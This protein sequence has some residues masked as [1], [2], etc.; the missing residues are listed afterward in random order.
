MENVYSALSGEEIRK[1]V[2][3]EVDKYLQHDSR[4]KRSL[5]YHKIGW[6]WTLNL[7]AYGPP[8]QTVTAEGEIYAKTL[9][10][11]IDRLKHEVIDMNDL[12]KKVHAER[13]QEIAL[14]KEQLH[15]AQEY[16]NQLL[17]QATAPAPQP[18]STTQTSESED[19]AVEFTIETTQPTIEEPD[20]IREQLA[21]TED[22]TVGRTLAEANPIGTDGKPAPVGAGRGAVVGGGKRPTNVFGRPK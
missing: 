22:L 7:K 18:T 3:Q 12:V 19:G 9:Q 17:E 13:D 1:A 21:P 16:S 8:P 5:A 20:R 6:K 11:E 14:I 4:F 10:E 15:A 2:V